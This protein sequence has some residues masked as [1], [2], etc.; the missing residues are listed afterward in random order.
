MHP[1]NNWFFREY[2]KSTPETTGFSENMEK[3]PEAT[4]PVRGHNP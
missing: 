1:R 3:A 2:G 4:G